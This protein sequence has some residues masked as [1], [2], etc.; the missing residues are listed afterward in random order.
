MMSLQDNLTWAACGKSGKKLSWSDLCNIT[1]KPVFE[2]RIALKCFD[3]NTYPLCW[4]VQSS[5]NDCN[6]SSSI[7]SAFSVF[8]HSA[9]PWI[10]HPVMFSSESLFFIFLA[11][12]YWIGLLRVVQC[13]FSSSQLRV[14]LNDQIFPSPA[15]HAGG[16][17]SNSTGHSV[18]VK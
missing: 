10:F 1:Q 18:L 4:M 9:G 8:I 11:E 16:K 6:K 14:L 2:S 5:K 13:C 12:Y 15:K 17:L 3:T 7:H